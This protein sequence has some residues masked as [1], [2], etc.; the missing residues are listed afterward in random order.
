MGYSF[1]VKYTEPAAATIANLLA[2]TPVEYIG[3]AIK[4]TIYG[5]A[6]AAGD[7][8]SLSSFRGSEPGA[9]V[10]PLGPIPVASTAGAIKTNENFIGQFAIPAGSRLVHNVVGT[11]AHTG[12]FL[13]VVE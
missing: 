3:E 5:S 4:L 1:P 8:H 7:T 9:L 11:A 10:I 2:G 12:Q 6:D 13:Y